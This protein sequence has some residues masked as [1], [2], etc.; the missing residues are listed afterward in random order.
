MAGSD[1]ADTH[2]HTHTIAA[3]QEPDLNVGLPAASATQP[4]TGETVLAQSAA[5]VAA[6]IA[7]EPG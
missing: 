1:P 5:E 4:S 7:N 3:A 2:G 6:Q